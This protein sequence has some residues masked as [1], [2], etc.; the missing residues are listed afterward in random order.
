MIEVIA[1][2]I[3]NNEVY[4]IKDKN[5]RLNV[6]RGSMVNKDGEI[7]MYDGKRWF[8]LCKS[9]SKERCVYIPEKE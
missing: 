6:R 1:K 9:D 8:F 5:I 7:H 3:P 4:F 2:P